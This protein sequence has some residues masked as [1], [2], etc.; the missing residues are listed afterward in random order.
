MEKIWDRINS[1]A[2]SHEEKYRRVQTKSK[3]NIQEN[4]KMVKKIL[5]IPIIMDE[6]EG[7]K[8]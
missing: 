8:F 1:W 3:E 5:H 7:K 6:G 2:A 4:K